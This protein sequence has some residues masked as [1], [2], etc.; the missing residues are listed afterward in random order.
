MQIHLDAIGG[1]A[2]D[3]FIAAVLDAF[4]DL[5][6]GMI[7]AIRA[8]GLPEDIVPHVVEHCDHVLTGLR[9]LVDEPP[10]RPHNRGLALPHEDHEHTPFRSIRAKLEAST[11]Q[12]AVHALLSALLRAEGIDPGLHRVLIEQV[13]RV[14]RLEHVVGLEREVEGLVALLLEARKTELRRNKLAAAAFV[15]CNVVEA[16]THAAVLAELEPK[17]AREVAEELTDMVLRYLPADC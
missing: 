15:L 5:Q 13:P 2:G 12:P 9:F 11:L 14:G 8:G 16:V 17:R 10:Y 1:V 3:M 7:E 6:E 4:P